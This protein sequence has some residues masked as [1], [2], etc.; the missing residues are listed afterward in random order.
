MLKII[1]VI[2]ILNAIDVMNTLTIIEA[3]GVEVNPFMD[4]FLQQSV[5]MFIAIKFTITSLGLLTLYYF[6]ATL[7]ISYIK[8]LLIIILI[9]YIILIT[10]QYYLILYLI[11]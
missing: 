9:I 3:G 1:A 10:Y 11:H 5:F 6:H 2:L 4:Y 8:Y 7:N